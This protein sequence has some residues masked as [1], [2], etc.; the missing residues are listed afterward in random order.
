MV[1]SQQD[2]RALLKQ[3]I[4]NM[5][6]HWRRRS[7]IELEMPKTLKKEFDKLLLEGKTY[8]QVTRWCN[9]GGFKFSQSGSA[10]TGKCSSKRTSI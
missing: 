7:K 6:I 8:K 3:D 9:D 5:G 10:A 1:L 2:K 4:R